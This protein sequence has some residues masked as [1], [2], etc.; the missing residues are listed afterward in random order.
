M[1]EKV[2]QLWDR[3]IRRSATTAYPQAQVQLSEISKTAAILFRALGGDGGLRLVASAPV[4]H[5]A[6][7]P[8]L[9]RIAGTQQRMALATRDGQTLR[10]PPVIDLFPERQ[11][12]HDL[13]LWLAAL[14]AATP[15]PGQSWFGA[16]Q[17]LAQHTLRQYP[18]L[19]A[20]YRRLVQAY[21]PLRPDPDTLPADEAAQEQAVRAALLAPGSVQQLPHARRPAWPVM[22]WLYPAATAQGAGPAQP[23]A[24]SGDAPTG[25]ASR[26]SE[27]RQRLKAERVD[28]PKKDGGI[29][30]Y[31]F[32]SIFSWTEYAKMDRASDDSEND[33]ADQAARD[34]DVLSVAR[35]QQT[36]TASRLRFDLDLPPE[37]DDDRVL[38]PGLPLPEWD[39]RKRILLP[40]HCRLQPMIAA[41]APKCA[42]PPALR[43]TARRLRRQFETLVND[44]TRVRGEEQG[45]D[46][47]LDAYLQRQAEERNHTGLRR[48]GLYIDQ[49]KHTRDLACLL[50]ADLSLSTDAWVNDQARVIDVVRDALF[51]F[52]EALS[53]TGDRFG[54]Y[55]FSSRRRDH[56]RFHILKDFSETYSAAVRGRIQA[57]RPGYYTRMGAA[58]RQASVLLGRETAGQRLLLLL[59]DGK[60]N[61]LDVYEGRYGIEDTRMALLEA[62]RQGLLPFCVTVDR[63]AG[64]YLPHLFGPDTYIVVRDPAELPRQLPLLYAR[65]TRQ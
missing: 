55:G 61:D 4:T 63:E 52:S 36:S 6:R 33:D 42:L 14:S 25:S 62:R 27:D 60:P 3:L 30:L 37:S 46:I 49:R 22:L 20:R 51:L 57:I 17:H 2:G 5:G 21:L 9:A 38:G 18:G 13:Y 12:N 24:D 35:D 47:D 44:K 16:N 31:R 11:L 10:L 43:A 58:I 26:R 19:A 7:R 56:V 64:S 41:S 15:P 45:G 39:Y 23:L 53:A 59:T 54:L 8:W 34:M 40:D 48:R 28:A 50:L 32:E 29:L 65:L 1:E